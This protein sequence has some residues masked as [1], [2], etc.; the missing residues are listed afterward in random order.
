[1]KVTGESFSSHHK[2]K[3]AEEARCHKHLNF[4]TK[5]LLPDRTLESFI[6]KSAE[7]AIPGGIFEEKREEQRKAEEGKIEYIKI[8]RQEEENKKRWEEIKKAEQ[9]YHSLNPSQQEEI[10]IETENRLPDYWKEKL[11]KV[12]GKGTTSKIL[13][14]VLEENR[15]EIVKEWI[16]KGKIKGMY[17][18][19]TLKI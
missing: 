10:R 7:G 18:R 4:Q 12:R 9:I 19:C 3:R 5:G 11:N 14:V 17:N 16:K 1:M 15:R 2:R 6:L 13:K 8:K